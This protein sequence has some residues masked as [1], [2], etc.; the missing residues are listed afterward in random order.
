MQHRLSSRFM[1]QISCGLMHA[2]W[3][4]M[5][6]NAAHSVVVGAFPAHWHPHQTEGRTASGLNIIYSLFY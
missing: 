3:R 5:Y 2:A 1:Y 4:A 6:V